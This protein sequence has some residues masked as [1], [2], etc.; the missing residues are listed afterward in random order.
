V[1]YS[2]IKGKDGRRDKVESLPRTITF[3]MTWRND[4][5]SIYGVV[6]LDRH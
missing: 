2:L 4:I 5:V 3:K 6:Y 1:D